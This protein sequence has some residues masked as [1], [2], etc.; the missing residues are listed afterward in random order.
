MI[1]SE[2]PASPGVPVV[3]RLE[4]ERRSNP[5]KLNLDRRKLT[6]CPI[7]EGEENLRLL[8]YQHNLIKKIEHLEL[9]R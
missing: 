4:E 7:L 9:L 3:Y 5:D 8:N 6:T 1:F 2:S